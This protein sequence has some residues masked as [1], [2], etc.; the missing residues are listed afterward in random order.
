MFALL[1]Q[2]GTVLGG[3]PDG[4]KKVLLLALALPGH[5]F[6]FTWGGDLLSL[7]HE[8]CRGAVCGVVRARNRLL[9][10][11]VACGDCDFFKSCRCPD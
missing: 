10:V 4:G 5:E 11:A 3:G 6:W 9:G 7:G 1:T 8:G 2:R